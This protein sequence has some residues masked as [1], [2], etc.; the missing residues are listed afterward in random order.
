M[1]ISHLIDAGTLPCTVSFNVVDLLFGR[2]LAGMQQRGDIRAGMISRRREGPGR[3]I[4][5]TCIVVPRAPFTVRVLDLIR[6][7]TLNLIVLFFTALPAVAAFIAVFFAMM[8]FDVSGWW[9]L[10]VPGVG[11]AAAWF[12]CDLRPDDGLFE[13]AC[14]DRK[15]GPLSDGN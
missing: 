4:P 1:T 3:R 11:S 5:G 2:V 8:Q 9:L 13:D 6:G 14:W 7:L 12:A 10:T 15:D